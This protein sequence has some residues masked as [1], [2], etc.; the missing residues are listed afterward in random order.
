M[1]QMLLAYDEVPNQRLL[2]TAKNMA[3]WIL[4]EG[5][6]LGDNLKTL[7][8][9][10]IIKREDSLNKSQKRQLSIISGDSNATEQEKVGAYLLLDNQVSAEMHFEKLTDE[11]QVQFKTFI[12]YMLAD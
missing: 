11:E 8:Y 2:T 10:Q 6:N 1:L 4:K 5:A 12:L 7:N 9:L 3:D